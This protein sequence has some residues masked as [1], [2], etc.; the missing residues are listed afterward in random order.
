MIIMALAAAQATGN[1]DQLTR[2]FPLL[3]QFANYLIE[4]GLAP[5]EQCVPSHQGEQS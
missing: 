3:S 4:N 1:T 5:V 2:Y